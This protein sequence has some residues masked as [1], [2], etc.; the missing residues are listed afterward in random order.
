MSHLELYLTGRI[1]AQ[2]DQR[3]IT[4]E[5]RTEKERALLA[6][7]A[8]ES[9]RSHMRDVIAE[10]FW[11]DRPA[12]VARTNLRQALS[13][14]RRALDDRK[15]DPPFI[16]SDDE[17]IQ[18]NPHGSFTLDVVSLKDE[19]LAVQNHPHAS[20]ESCPVCVRHLEKAVGIYRGEFMEGIYLDDSQRGQEWITFEREQL[21]TQVL[22]AVQNLIAYFTLQGD[23]EQALK[24][25]QQLVSL[26][27]YEESAHRTL[28][29]MFSNI[30][31]R[32]AALEQYQT[33]KRILQEELG[34]EPSAETT[35]LYSLIKAGT[36]APP[37]QPLSAAVPVQ[38]PVPIT[39]FIG[40]QTELDWFANCLSNAT[41]RLVTL[42]GMPGS[43][44][45]RLAMEA[46]TR[47]SQFFPD[48]VKFYRLEA[49]KDPALLP[50][51]LARGLGV[52]LPASLDPLQALGNLLSPL[53]TLLIL[54]GF[55]HLLGATEML[56][57]LLRS[58]EQLKILVTSRRRLDYQSVC[59]I[60]LGGLQYPPHEK[61]DEPEQ[62]PAV[63]LFVG[64]ATR[65]QPGFQLEAPQLIQLVR[66]CRL[67]DGLPLGL[68]VAAAALRDYTLGQIA[69]LME[70]SPSSLA[71]GL[72]DV[73]DRQR[74]LWTMMEDFWRQLSPADQAALS[75]LS[76]FRDSFNA[77]AAQAVTGLD[78]RA[79]SN[80]ADQSLIDRP[81]PYTFGLHPLV[82]QYAFQ[83][84]QSE[85]T[86]AAQYQEAHCAYYL[87]YLHRH[88]LALRAY[89]ESA[90]DALRLV[91][92]DL[93][94]ALNWASLRGRSLEAAEGQAMLKRYFETCMVVKQKDC[95]F[96]KIELALNEE[97]PGLV[98]LPML[99]QHL[100]RDDSCCG[101]LGCLS[102]ADT[103]FLM[104]DE[105]HNIVE[106]NYQ[107]SQ[108]LGAP[109]GELVGM[110]I[111]SWAPGVLDNNNNPEVSL[112]VDLTR[113]DGLKVSLQVTRSLVNAGGERFS[114]LI[115]QRRSEGSRM[116]EGLP[117]AG[118]DPLT[119]LPN[120]DWFRTNLMQY[121]SRASREL[122]PFAVFLI[123]MG[124]IRTV[125][126]LFGK[127]YGDKVVLESAQRLRR[128]TRTGDTVARFS[129]QDF[130]MLLDGLAE[131]DLGGH[132][133]NLSVHIGL[134]MSTGGGDGVDAVLKNADEALQQ[135]KRKGDC[136]YQ[137]F[138]IP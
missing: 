116:H 45:S 104:V 71:V 81:T 123:E 137:L 66:I 85:P 10:L 49:V 121:L 43:G 96:W 21:Y 94:Q 16:I 80:L 126:E 138:G 12:G 30:G 92:D 101:R 64:R 48:G 28:M 105:E 4:R 122:R 112:P 47:F 5:F 53:N 88:Q 46:A 19:I 68:E 106:A 51:Y 34:V 36:L 129:T 11:P 37:T 103:G 115:L 63:Q 59:M 56:L 97:N 125:N 20:L 31:R 54:D 117:M 118:F 110:S 76:V 57:S 2:L 89:S 22:T 7:L 120:R 134:V 42:I 9:D 128:R 29:Q 99:Q 58:A 72:K 136:A 50:G 74:S 32:S 3:D 39:S 91:M 23:H 41:C 113:P 18:F 15:N 100:T 109:R 62:F 8:V 78:L 98:H 79:L 65:S 73:P 70:K 61:V 69:D 25:A 27:P 124:G 127:E 87:E 75:H 17:T 108:I 67:V 135:S 26:A 131:V 6:F 107:A 38:V 35:A 114:L 84:L 86:Q 82:R 83:R 33:C 60:E 1:E 130:A 102:D 55:E 90:V 111:T 14:I 52:E 24:F 119:S 44:K 77:E 93:H 133:I 132:S 40:R 95:I 13:G